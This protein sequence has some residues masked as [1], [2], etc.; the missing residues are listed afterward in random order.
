MSP[1]ELVAR[2]LGD[3]RLCYR[4]SRAAKLLDYGKTAL[5]EMIAK[6]EI[7]AVVIGGQKRIPVTELLR[8]IEI[9][10]PDDAA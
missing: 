3:P 1:D 5:Y 8:L 10:G 6:G 7:K 9:K 4:V 2:I